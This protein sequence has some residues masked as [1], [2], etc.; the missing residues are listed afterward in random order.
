MQNRRYNSEVMESFLGFVV[1]LGILSGSLLVYLKLSENL[2]KGKHTMQIIIGVAFIGINI[3][4]LS[5]GKTIS[6]SI[7]SEFFR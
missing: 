7:Y 3:V 2:L 5:S 6:V 1:G 4:S